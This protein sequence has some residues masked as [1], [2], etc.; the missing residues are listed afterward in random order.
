ME[1]SVKARAMVPC[2][3]ERELSHDAP[4]EE[5]AC[6]EDGDGGGEGARQGAKLRG[7]RVPPRRP[8]CELRLQV[9]KPFGGEAS[10]HLDAVQ[11]DA[12][13]D[14]P[15]RG[16]LQLAR[17]QGDAEVCAD[18]EHGVDVPLALA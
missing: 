1:A 8:R 18:F 4:E 12:E 6:G 7:C 13:E 10:D 11:L 3:E 15:R 9:G 2:L 5:T 14:E 17:G 16:P